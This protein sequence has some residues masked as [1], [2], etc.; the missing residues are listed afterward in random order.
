MKVQHAKAQAKFIK[1]FAS[2]EKRESES[3]AYKV[4]GKIKKDYASRAKKRKLKCS[5]QRPRQK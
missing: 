2:R 5:I 4:P 3:A 1:N